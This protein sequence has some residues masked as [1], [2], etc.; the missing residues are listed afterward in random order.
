[1]AKSAIERFISGY[2]RNKRLSETKEGYADWLRKN[3]A[4]PMTEL[5]GSI[6]RVTSEY[7]KDASMHGSDASMLS[8][9]G[10]KRSGYADFLKDSLEEKRERGFEN[11][12]L[13]Y[14]DKDI[15]NE[16]GYEDELARREAIRLEEE[17]KAEEER[18]KAEKKAE[19][20]R[21]KAEK[22]ARDE[23]IKASE[24]A[25]KLEEE[26][27]KN[28]KKRKEKLYSTV[29]TELEKRKTVKYDDAYEYALYMGLDE[30]TA[31][32]LA[33]ATTETARSE[34]INKVTTAI[35]N[36]GLSMNQ[37]KKYAESLGLSEED[38]NALAELAFSAN[39]SVDDITS[40]EDYLEYLKDKANQNN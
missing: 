12:A 4:D 11:A 23:A 15:K 24:K 18:L 37:A 21:L 20:E 6:A 25:K 31:A 38:V 34:A 39:E 27:L 40:Y 16:Q 7:E 1:M 35:F 28:D 30:T 13:E 36:K 33:K 32:S 9:L 22:E 19:E 14:I 2:L 3:G 29:K 17:R 10:L 8:D 26:R 5:D